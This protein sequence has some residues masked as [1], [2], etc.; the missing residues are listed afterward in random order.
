MAFPQTSVLELKGH[1]HGLDG[2]PAD[3]QLDLLCK[4]AAGL[5]VYAVATVKFVNHRN[6]NPKE[7]LDHLLQ[8]PDSSVYEGKTEFKTDTTLDSLYMSILQEAFGHDDPEDDPKVCS[9]LG[10][11]VLAA[12][13]LPPSA[14]AA[15]SGIDPITVS[16][17]LSS[18]NSLLLLQEGDYPVQPFHK[19]FPD[20]IVDPARCTNQRF[21]ISPPD[22]HSEL[23]I[24]CLKLMNERLEKNMCKIPDGATNSEVDDLQERASKYI[25]HGLRYGCESWHKHLDHDTAPAYKL[26]I[27]SALHKFLEEKF[28]FWLDVLSVLGTIR[29]AVNALKAAADWVEVC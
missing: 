21:C 14:I 1:C 10:A 18:I 19:S 4:R 29:D 12:N 20:F 16:F 3:E 11:V 7:R 25:D 2:W 17:Q 9:V 22:H 28:L 8:S 26:R 5:F 15:L 13:P 6:H 24:G 23:L 27:T